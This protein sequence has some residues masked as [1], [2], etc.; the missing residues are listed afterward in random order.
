VGTHTHVQTAD[1]RVLPGGTAYITDLG[2]TGPH[3]SVIGVRTDI[4]VSRFLERGQARFAPA[5]GWVAIQGLA[6]ECDAAGRATAV[7]RISLPV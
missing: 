7:E 2:M 4:I 1:E 3:D 6:V 5:E